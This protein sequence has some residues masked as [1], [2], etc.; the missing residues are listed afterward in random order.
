MSLILYDLEE[1][2][3][4]VVVASLVELRASKING[5][6]APL[7]FK[8]PK[9]I[10][11]PKKEERVFLIARLF[12]MFSSPGSSTDFSSLFNDDVSDVDVIDDSRSISLFS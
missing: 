1:E 7:E 6:R 5:S 8:T 9:T 11:R 12:N 4:V 10:V 3:D 2:E